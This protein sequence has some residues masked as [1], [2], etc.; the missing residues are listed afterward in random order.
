MTDSLPKVPEQYECLQDVEDAEDIVE[1]IKGTNK[2]NPIHAGLYNTHSHLKSTAHRIVKL[3]KRRQGKSKTSVNPHSLKSKRGSIFSNLIDWDERGNTSKH[4]HLALDDVTNI[5]C[6]KSSAQNN[7]P[8]SRYASP[9]ASIARRAVDSHPSD[10]PTFVTSYDGSHRAPLARQAVKSPLFPI[11]EH[12]DHSQHSQTGGY[13]TLGMLK[14]ECKP[15]W[16]IPLAR[17]RPLSSPI[18]NSLSRSQKTRDPK[19]PPKIRGGADV[20]EGGSCVRQG[21]NT[22]CDAEK[23]EADQDYIS[24]QRQEEEGRNEATLLPKSS[25]SSFT[26]GESGLR[27]KSQVMKG[28]SS[29]SGGCR[30]IVSFLSGSWGCHQPRSLKNYSDGL[31]GNPNDSSAGL[32]RNFKVYSSR[33]AVKTKSRWPHL[34]KLA[35]A[36]KQVFGRVL[37]HRGDLI[38]VNM[39]S[40]IERHSQTVS[41]VPDIFKGSDFDEYFSGPT[42]TITKDLLEA[43]FKSHFKSGIDKKQHKTHDLTNPNLHALHWEKTLTAP[44]I[45][46]MGWLPSRLWKANLSINKKLEKSRNEEIKW[47]VRPM[48]NA[49]INQH[50]NGKYFIIEQEATSAQ[51]QLS[52]FETLVRVTGA[53]RVNLDHCRFESIK[54]KTSTFI[55]NIP[56]FILEPLNNKKCECSDVHKPSPVSSATNHQPLLA[57]AIVK[58]VSACIQY[59]RATND[60][61]QADV[62]ESMIRYLDS[63]EGETSSSVLDSGCQH[64]CLN[65]KQWRIMK[66]D[67]RSFAAKG[68]FGKAITIQTGTCAAVVKDS[69]GKDVLLVIN[70]AGLVE[71]RV[72]LIDPYQLMAAGCEVEHVM[73]KRCPGPFIKKDGIIIPLTIGKDITIDVAYPTLSQLK[74]L[75]RITLS[76]TKPWDRASYMSLRGSIDDID[77]NLVSMNSNE[78]KA[79]SNDS[80]DNTDDPESDVDETVY[81]DNPSGNHS[82]PPDIWWWL[83]KNVLKRTANA[84]TAFVAARKGNDDLVR[85]KTNK[86]IAHRRIKDSASHDTLYSTV[87]ARHCGSTMLQVFATR[88]SRYLFGEPM[89]LKS[90]VLPITEN[91]FKAV[92]IPATL[93][94]D[95]AKENHSAKMQA[96]LRKH[97]VQEEHTEEFMQFQNPVERWIGFLKR[98]IFKIMHHSKAPPDEWLE[99]AQYVIACHNKTARKSLHWRTPWEMVFGDTPDLSELVD[100][101]FYQPVYYVADPNASSFP[102]PK[103]HEAHYL[104]PAYHHGSVLCHWIRL[105]DGSKIAKSLLRPNHDAHAVLK[106][107]EM[108]EIADKQLYYK[109][110]MSSTLSKEAERNDDNDKNKDLWSGYETEEEEDVEGGV[111]VDEEEPALTSV[112]NDSVWVKIGRKQVTATAV[113]DFYVGAKRWITVRVK[114]RVDEDWTFD[115]FKA[116]QAVKHNQRDTAVPY[117]FTS[118][119]K[120]KVLKADPK[121]QLSSRIVIKVGW[122]DG[123]FTW[124]PFNNIT[125]VRRTMVFLLLAME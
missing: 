80:T 112:I 7:E 125:I 97:A 99:C 110:G 85:R 68:Y 59:Y 69:R 81:A 105:P 54:N 43:G 32:A 51:L 55:T 22:G 87:P 92:G 45:V 95:N 121:R 13:T 8:T 26:L 34:R 1:F 53:R 17:Y 123:T 25:P 49:C 78:A 79:T 9:D 62:I 118:L 71:D 77:L 119:D 36:S 44:P 24:P 93:R 56:D 108:E 117:A 107:E 28:V 31:Y 86:A 101:K 103:L 73:T 33:D 21:S 113:R 39:I 70:S 96:L 11:E 90:Q 58:V 109:D 3:G 111:D 10:K 88:K 67:G 14:E 15:R 20:V 50:N 64:S 46:V 41:Q 115:K 57:K 66:K 29:L 94:S 52:V 35:N 98:S 42:G 60:M 23:R 100:Y 106:E 104:G 75:P 18:K 83:D 5:F 72:S 82:L 61:L 114:D 124:E 27:T 120:F 4:Q 38:E 91:F 16:L 89:T 63:L 47:L 116:L 6:R 40:A 19:L 12:Q 65:V 102:E 122:S 74:T 30:K 2:L 84:T 37:P 48:I 76:S